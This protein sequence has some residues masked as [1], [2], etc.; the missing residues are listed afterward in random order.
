M[1]RGNDADTVSYAAFFYKLPHAVGYV[2]EFCPG[3]GMNFHNLFVF[4]TLNIPF[5]IHL[6]MKVCMMV[7]INRDQ[8]IFLKQYTYAGAQEL[9]EGI[10]E[11]VEKLLGLD[12]EIRI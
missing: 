3:R 12:K 11:N 2:N 1:A 10:S 6:C 7:Y 5:R 9:E 4:Q 8:M